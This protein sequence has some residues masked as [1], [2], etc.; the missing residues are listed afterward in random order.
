MAAEPLDLGRLKPPLKKE[1]G[2][3][4]RLRY[5]RKFYGSHSEFITDVQNVI[6]V[7]DFVYIFACRNAKILNLFW[8]DAFSVLCAITVSENSTDLYWW[9]FRKLK[10]NMYKRFL[11]PIILE[12]T[13]IIEIIYFHLFSN[14][15]MIKT[16]FVFKDM[17]LNSPQYSEENGFLGLR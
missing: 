9:A 10:G 2:G 3:L 16:W 1:W 13:N 8:K 14:R 7:V 15:K 4:G 5:L 6:S 12:I 11:L 17:L